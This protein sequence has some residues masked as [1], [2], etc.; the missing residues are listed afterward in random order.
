MGVS[1]LTNSIIHLYRGEM[2]RLLAYRVRLDTCT[3]WAVT[4]TA[5]MIVFSLGQDKIPHY[6]HVVICVFIFIFLLMEGRR[7]GYYIAVKSRVRQIEAGFYGRVLLGQEFG[8]SMCGL[9]STDDPTVTGAEVVDDDYPPREGAA[10]FKSP[11]VHTRTLHSPSPS[12]QVTMA[13]AGLSAGLDVRRS[14]TSMGDEEN[15]SVEEQMEREAASATNRFA[16]LAPRDIRKATKAP[17]PIIQPYVNDWTHLLYH[18]L[19]YPEVNISLLDSILV[20]LRRVYI[21]LLL[22]VLASWIIKVHLDVG[23]KHSW[24][25]ILIVC[26]VYGIIIFTVSY[27]L[28]KQRSKMYAEKHVAAIFMQERK[29]RMSSRNLI[30]DQHEKAHWWKRTKTNDGH[31]RKRNNSSC[32]TV[33]STSAMAA[34]GAPM[35]PHLSV[36]GPY[37]PSHIYGPLNVTRVLNQSDHMHPGHPPM[38]PTVHGHTQ[39]VSYQDPFQNAKYWSKHAARYGMENDADL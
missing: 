37:P 36:P 29:K 2:S 4:V 3:N 28:P 12:P 8:R 24:Y 18:S 20:R 6:F 23:L 9:I 35:A 15:R 21:L 25:M 38:P 5:A 34:A 13:R 19:L 30:D 17:M 11:F 32:T 26:V 22:G 31:L 33:G 1:D 39:S 7:H 16:P 14:S 10:L 27:Y